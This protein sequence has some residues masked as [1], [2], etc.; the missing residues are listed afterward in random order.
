MTHLP[1]KSRLPLIGATAAL[2]LLLL[3]LPSWLFPRPQNK[4][5]A[6]EAAAAHQQSLANSSW[7]EPWIPI[8]QGQF[9]TAFLPCSS[10]DQALLLDQ[11]IDDG[12]PHSGNLVL[13]K[14]GVAWQP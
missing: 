13:C 2:G 8:R 9:S 7:Q 5:W 3:I 10:L 1:S 4:E 14:G 11:L 6:K 12:H